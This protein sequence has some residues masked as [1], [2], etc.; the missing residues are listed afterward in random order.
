MATDMVSTDIRDMGT[1]R[2]A[3]AADGEPDTA[4]GTMR[5]EAMDKDLMADMAATEATDMEDI[6]DTVVTPAT[7]TEA[8]D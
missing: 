8:T 5:S 7:A 2:A 4:T 3:M 6:T 1:I